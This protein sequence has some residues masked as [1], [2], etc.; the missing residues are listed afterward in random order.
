MRKLML[1]ILMFSSLLLS[2][3]SLAEKANSTLEYVNHAK[4]HINNLSDFAEQA[5]GMIQDA[6]L[7]P[8]AK[9]QLE[10]RLNGLKTD[11]EQFNLTDAPSVAK[12][13][14]Q[15]L[16][17]KNKVLLQDLNQVVDN[18]HLSLDKI[19]NSQFLTTINNITGLINRINSLGL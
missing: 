2:A 18:G 13:I 5:P 7:N 12:D 1:L 3:C 17:D 15:Q 4:D 8:E 16:V 6:A 10:N 9:Q 19:Q 11:I 14:H